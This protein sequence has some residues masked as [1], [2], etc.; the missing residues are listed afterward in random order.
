MYPEIST[1]SAA[2]VASDLEFLNSQRR[3]APHDT[4][5]APPPLWGR[6]MSFTPQNGSGLGPGPGPNGMPGMNRTTTNGN[7]NVPPPSSQSQP[8]VGP[9]QSGS[10]MHPHPNQHPMGFDQY[11][12]GYGPG[13]PPPGRIRDQPPPGPYP[14]SQSGP[15]TLGPGGP[16]ENVNAYPN[17]S[18]P[19]G[20][21]SAPHGV[22][23]GPGGQGYPLEHDMNGS[24][25]PGSGTGHQ[26]MPHHP[27]F[28]QGS[29]G[30][31]SSGNPYPPLSSHHHG[32]GMKVA[33]I[34]GRRSPSPHVLP[35]GSSSASGKANGNWM[36][37]GMG[38]GTFH[39][40]NG[41]GGDRDVRMTHEDE[42]K[43]R[44]MVE[45]ERESRKRAERD[46]KMDR[47][48][49]ER[50]LERRHKEHQEMER[51]RREQQHL[52]QHQQHRQGSSSGLP[53]VHSGGVGGL[54]PT[55]G[56]GVES[57]H[58]HHRTHHHHHVLHRHGPQHA[59]SSLPPPGPSGPGGVPPIV[60]SPRSARDYEPSRPPPPLHTGP[61][62][63]HPTEVILLKSS[64][65]RDRDSGGHW[66]AKNEDPHHNSSSIA[67]YRDNRERDMRKPYSQ[68]PPSRP[69]MIPL[70]AG[71]DRADRPMA[72]PFVMASSH[73]M[74]QVTAS[75]PS[76]PYVNGSGAGS[77]A[78]SPRD[79]RGA[80]SWN[81]PG[82]EEPPYRMSST[83]PPG[84]H[85]SSHDP[86]VRSPVQ[87]HRY[88]PGGPPSSRMSTG[89]SSS[90]IHRI[91]SP[92]PPSGRARPPQSP[93]YPHSNSHRS[94]A[95]R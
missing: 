88:G 6:T 83:A 38:M 39:L 61:G 89:G 50:D 40:G 37:I 93:S 4:Q 56:S 84:Y 87:A 27:Y 22:M 45:R 68:R 47:R 7:S 79:Q 19:G 70:D 82:G 16:R 48:E 1:L 34:N 2:E 65:A 49:Q 76:G 69:P 18:G 74:Q 11:G 91:S 60:H 90:S 42:E 26:L 62:Q 8:M 53:H 85:G 80:P 24:G 25:G 78:T 94:P 13:G 63:P 15:P 54:A 10:I 86:H 5:P 44:M 30:P 64:Q 3:G 41:K 51:E 95:T 81:T 29:I 21:Q 72:T 9:P 59:S 77:A 43:E 66:P 35:N 17:F 46:S 58:H 32:S 14:H 55:Q 71:D 33:T 36:G 23:P 73:T 28:S 12:D 57:H 20:R 31:G 67:D 52:Q 75:T 92:P